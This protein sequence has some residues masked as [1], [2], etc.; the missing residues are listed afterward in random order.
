MA[1]A[2]LEYGY[3]VKAVRVDGALHLKTAIT[4][5]GDDTFV[6]NPRWVDV[7]RFAGARL[8]EVDPREP[9][10][11]NVLKAGRRLLAS[12]AAPRT[13]ATGAPASSRRRSRASR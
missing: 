7:E 11:A 3:R 6:V 13:A 5:L 2:V 12:A 9:F 1:H 8:I 4:W 10:G